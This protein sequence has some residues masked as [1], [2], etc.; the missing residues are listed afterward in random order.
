ME[1][2]GCG[3]DAYGLYSFDRHDRLE[4]NGQLNVA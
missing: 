1:G 2:M 3:D 4:A